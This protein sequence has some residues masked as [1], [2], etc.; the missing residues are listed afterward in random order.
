[1]KFTHFAPLPR[2]PFKILEMQFFL[3]RLFIDTYLQVYV[4][5]FSRIALTVRML[6]A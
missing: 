2:V 3:H 6:A 4:E 5:N 1:M